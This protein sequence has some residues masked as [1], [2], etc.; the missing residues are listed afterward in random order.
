MN[1]KLTQSEISLVLEELY[2]SWDMAREDLEDN[3]ANKIAKTRD[4]LVQQY[5]EQ[6]KTKE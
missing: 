5:N 1:F 4:K 6:I 3:K 2:R